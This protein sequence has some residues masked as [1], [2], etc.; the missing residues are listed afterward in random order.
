MSAEGWILYDVERVCDVVP[1]G[2]P[3]AIPVQA[4]APP[5]TVATLP[6]ILFENPA[7]AIASFPWKCDFGQYTSDVRLVF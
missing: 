5:T 6:P 2:A 3:V 7:N 1:V 4:T